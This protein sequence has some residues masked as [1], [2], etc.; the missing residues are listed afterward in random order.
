[1]DRITRRAFARQAVPS[2]AL[3]RQSVESCWIAL[4][5]FQ[6]RRIADVFSL[7]HF[8]HNEGLAVAV[9]HVLEPKT[10]LPPDEIDDGAGRGHLIG[11]GAEKEIAFPHVFHRLNRARAAAEN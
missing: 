9:R 8:A 1:M 11:S 7:F 5:N 10:M 4:N 3:K 6:L 2:S